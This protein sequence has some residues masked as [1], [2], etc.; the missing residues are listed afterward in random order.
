MTKPSP[1]IGILLMLLATAVLASKDG[2]AKTFLDQVGPFQIIWI[3]FTGTFFIMALIC[4]PKYGWRVFLPKPAVG[5][6]VR[7]ALNAAAIATLYWALTYI[8]LADGV[9]MFMFAPAVVT[10]LSPFLL[11]E[12]IGPL[13]VL[14]VAVGFCSV[15]IILKPGFGGNPHGYYIGMAS[16]FLMGLYFIANRRLAGSQPPLLNVTHNALTG[17]LA[18]TPFLQLFW[19]PIPVSAHTKLSV[20][21]V[22]AII[23][24]GLM[25]SSFV[26][27]PA[28]VL[29]PYTYAMLVFAALIGY[30]F[31]GSV[32]DNMT[33]IGIA[34]IIGSGI[35]IAL[36]EQQLANRQSSR[37]S[38]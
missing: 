36:R 4:I 34:M 26:F 30:V 7:G 20:L 6:F 27:A 13:R 18:L 12:K 14:A 24:Q 3:Q 9:A 33:W 22:L 1:L 19:L 10:L 11:G 31:L 17:A 38:Q 35:F 37:S 29:A 16:G 5:Q 21:V 23:G 8:P 2:L 32:P 28:A 15:L 25:I